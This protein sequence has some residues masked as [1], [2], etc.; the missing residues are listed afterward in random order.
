MICAKPVSYDAVADMLNA[1]ASDKTAT[2]GTVPDMA[3]LAAQGQCYAVYEHEQLRGAYV[4]KAI[5]GECWVLAAAGR[6]EF[7][8]TAVLADVINQQAQQF[9]TIGFQTARRGLVKKAQ[10]HGYEI[11]GYI[12]RKRV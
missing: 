1:A 3:S 12:L 7:D 2:A 10:R 9:K 6:A 11:A 5:G 8:L 4:L